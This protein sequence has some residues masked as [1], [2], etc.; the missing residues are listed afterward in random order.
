MTFSEYQVEARKTAIYPEIKSTVVYPI[1][2]LVGEVGELI[3][4]Y[5][6]KPIGVDPTG[7]EKFKTLVKEMGDVCWYVSAIA[8]ELGLKDLSPQE[9]LDFQ[10]QL[11]LSPANIAE[12]TKK[13]F[14]DKNGVFSDE[15]KEYIKQSLELVLG[16]IEEMGNDVGVHMDDIL[17]VNIAKLASRKERGVIKGSGDER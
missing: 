5:L 16:A 4:S 17:G 12:R 10:T 15:D 1:L 7:D 6:R 9:D 14:R 11:T 2:G 8:D 13:V 3:E